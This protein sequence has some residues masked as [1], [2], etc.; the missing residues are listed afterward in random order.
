MIVKREGEGWSLIAQ[1]DHGAHTGEIARAWREGPFGPDAVSDSLLLAAAQHDRGWREWDLAPATDLA[2]GP[3]N[4][5]RIDEATHTAFYSG[6][7]QAIAGEDV[8]A[9]YLVSLHASGLYGRRFGWSGLKPV[10][11]TAVG[12]EGGRL[13]ERE[14]GVR[15]DLA[16]RMPPAEL[17]FESAWRSYMLLETF[18]FLSL[19]TC[20]EVDAGGCGPV[21]AE[22]GRWGTLTIRHDGP[23]EKAVDPFPFG[24]SELRVTVPR[25]HLEQADFRDAQEL[26]AA[27]EAAPRLQQE[28]VYRA[29]R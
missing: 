25:R 17:E 1:V 21:P 9:A 20:F 11:W 15:R 8:G 4:F 13:L 10:D 7:V 23:W 19:L 28:T 18:D 29:V 26:R 24:G 2:G 22:P 5:T 12:E 27:L 16:A 14:R 3:L 6:A